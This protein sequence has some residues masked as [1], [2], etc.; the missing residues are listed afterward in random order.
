MEDLEGVCS[1]FPSCTIAQKAGMMEVRRRF[2]WA[3]IPILAGGSTSLE[4]GSMS[5]EMHCGN[6]D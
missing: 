4:V 5:P 6:R 2:R 3:Q 1:F